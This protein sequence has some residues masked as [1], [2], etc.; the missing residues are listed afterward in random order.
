MMAINWGNRTEED[1]DGIVSKIYMLMYQVQV[2]AGTIKLR[3]T[4]WG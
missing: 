4:N 3:K 2:M 1:V